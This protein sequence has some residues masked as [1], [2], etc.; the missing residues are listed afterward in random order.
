MT[1][2]GI[3]LANLPRAS[4]ANFL[5]TLLLFMEVL[6][7]FMDFLRMDLDL[8]MALEDLFIELL[9][10]FMAFLRMDLFVAL[11][12]L[13][14]E[15]LDLFPD[16]FVALEDLFS[17]N[18]PLASLTNF[19]EALLLC[20]ELLDLFLAPEDILSES[21]SFKSFTNFPGE[22]L[23]FIELLDLLIDFLGMDLDLF[24]EAEDI[25]FE[26][27]PLFMELLMATFLLGF[28]RNCIAF[29]LEPAEV[30][31][32]RGV[33]L[34]GIRFPFTII[35]GMRALDFNPET[36]IFLPLLV[37]LAFLDFLFLLEVDSFPK[38]NSTSLLTSRCILLVLDLTIF[39]FSSTFFEMCWS[40][41]EHDWKSW[42]LYPGLHSGLFFGVHIIQLIFFILFC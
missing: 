33:D 12:D 27:R 37:D 4:L 6:D 28:L 8:F 36:F 25:F 20:M 19:P 39:D 11:E 38:S 2:D 24:L 9:D 41:E 32:F 15:L 3:F 30:D 42:Y 34:R 17:A 14:M 40:T 26:G 23:L 35:D 22:L 16:L 5:E 10:L 7:L 1:L 18:L 13:F 31:I 21:Q 29:F